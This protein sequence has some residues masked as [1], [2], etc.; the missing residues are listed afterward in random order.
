MNTPTVISESGT[1]NRALITAY[2]NAKQGAVFRFEG[3]AIIL[4]GDISGNAAMIGSRNSSPVMMKIC[5][6]G[7]LSAIRST[8]SASIVL[9][10][11]NVS[12]CFGCCFLLNGQKRSPDPPAMMSAMCFM[13]SFA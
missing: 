11:N 5:S 6:L 12:N 1:L 8:A 13:I 2:P 9:S 3:S 7:M 10:E 4:S